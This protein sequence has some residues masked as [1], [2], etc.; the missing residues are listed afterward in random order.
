[1][2]NLTIYLLGAITLFVAA[3]D[4]NDRT[5]KDKESSIT[6]AMNYGSQ[7]EFKS[8]ARTYTFPNVPQ[9]VVDRAI[10]EYGTGSLPAVTIALTYTRGDTNIVLEDGWSFYN[11]SSP[12]PDCFI[13]DS[14]DYQGGQGMLTTENGFVFLEHD[15]L[16]GQGTYILDNR[17]G[18]WFDYVCGPD[19]FRFDYYGSPVFVLVRL[20]CE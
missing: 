19:S 20:W 8:S 2:K 9:E 14:I 13:G 10:S 15:A 11:Y 18:G 6:N 5:Q 4:T 1:M 7:A 3:C 17:Q 12:Q 16:C